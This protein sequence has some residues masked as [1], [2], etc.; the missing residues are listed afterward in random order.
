M[1]E[2][3][4]IYAGL[5]ESFPQL[6]RTVVRAAAERFL[7][8]DDAAFFLACEASEAHVHENPACLS[9]GSEGQPLETRSPSAGAGTDELQSGH[10]ASQETGTNA[11]DSWNPYLEAA[12]LAANQSTCLDAE[13]SAEDVEAHISHESPPEGL[14][15]PAVCSSEPLRNHEEAPLEEAVRGIEPPEERTLHG[16]QE[17]VAQGQSPTLEMLVQQSVQEKERLAAEL[18]AYAQMRNTAAALEVELDA[19][20]DRANVAGHA[21]QRHMEQTQ[22][23]VAR[24]SEENERRSGEVHG[25]LAMLGTEAKELRRNLAL[26]QE[27]RRAIRTTL[28][29][30]QVGLRERMGATEA[31]IVLA[32]A[33]AAKRRAV[34]QAALEVVQTKLD[35]AEVEKAD[36]DRQEAEAN[37]LHLFIMEKG[38][39]VDSMLAEVA[40]LREDLAAVERLASGSGL[41]GPL[42]P[43]SFLTVGQAGSALRRSSH[44]QGETIL[45][46]AAEIET[47]SVPQTEADTDHPEVSAASASEGGSPAGNIDHAEGH[48]RAVI[49]SSDSTAGDSEHSLQSSLPSLLSLSAQSN[50]Q[51]TNSSM[52]LSQAPGGDA[53]NYV[54]DRE[55]QGGVTASNIVESQEAFDVGSAQALH[56]GLYGPSPSNLTSQYL[57]VFQQQVGPHFDQG[58][59]ED[60]GWAMLESESSSSETQH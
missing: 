46:R 5:R 35:K 24:L 11:L 45:S 21:E 40:M 4:V 7:N 47:L 9:R 22:Q 13:T 12:A 54:A 60:E 52:R 20:R 1:A 3:R 2:W 55:N 10:D 31:A 17:T 15:G 41:S 18:A 8:E 6:D 27:E 28:E 53:S 48:P 59:I 30:L 51:S 16:S 43:S 44:S 56:M 38:T 37:K 58:E 25:E 32:D 57:G 49:P 36:L 14:L 19:A 33:E 23:A 50:F 34:V 29:H 42:A 26:L 39:M